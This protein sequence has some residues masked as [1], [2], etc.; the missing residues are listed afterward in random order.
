MN[1]EEGEGAQKKLD[2]DID[3]I[4]IRDLYLADLH[5]DTDDD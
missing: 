3:Y 1:T 4:Y 5:D 2:I